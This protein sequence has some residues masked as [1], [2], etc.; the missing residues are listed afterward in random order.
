MRAR[1]WDLAEYWASD[2]NVFDAGQF[3][4]DLRDTLGLDPAA[5]AP[6][7]LIEGTDAADTLRGGNGNDT[8]N[9]GR[10]GDT[11]NGGRGDD[12]IDGGWGSDTINGGAG[13]DTIHGGNDADLMTGGRGADIFHFG[14]RP[15][16]TATFID[17]DTVGTFGRGPASDTITDFRPGQD[18]IDVSAWGTAANGSDAFTIVFIGTAPFS[19]VGPHP[20]NSDGSSGAP[21]S[22]VNPEARYEWRDGNTHVQFD[23]PVG[24]QSLKHG[25]SPMDAKAD[26]EIV[27]LGL[28]TLS[29]ADFVL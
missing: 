5:A 7:R 25:M 14:T 21:R 12:T 10:G 2:T 8:I 22:G 20:R 15:W 3:L 6:G 28:H 11:I 13:D 9:G 18:K 24:F 27:L 19:S 26:A 29:E 16:D 4:A 1:P 23:G 17:A